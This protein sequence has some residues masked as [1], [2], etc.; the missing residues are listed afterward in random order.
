MVK[1]AAASGCT[2]QQR[3]A[4]YAQLC[5]TAKE[6]DNKTKACSM[7]TIKPSLLSQ[8]EGASVHLPSVKLC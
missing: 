3:P 6:D 7:A 1:M 4:R 8:C 5:M 2:G